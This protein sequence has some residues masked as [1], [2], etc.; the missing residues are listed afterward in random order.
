LICRLPGRSHRPLILQ[1]HSAIRTYAG[2]ISSWQKGKAAFERIVT[3]RHAALK[4]A[5]GF[6]VL[7]AV[8]LFAAMGV[9]LAE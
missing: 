1:P 7:G 8:A 2:N 3:Y 6:L 4:V 5:G 9:Y